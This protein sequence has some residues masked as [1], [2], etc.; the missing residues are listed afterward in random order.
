MPYKPIHKAHNAGGNTPV[1]PNRFLKDKRGV[2]FTAMNLLGLC[3]RMVAV[4]TNLIA[5]FI[6][7]S[8]LSA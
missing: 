4:Y 7:S 6:G 5:W 2:A 3:V 1:D 8:L